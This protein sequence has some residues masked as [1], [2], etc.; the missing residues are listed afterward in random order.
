[1][2]LVYMAN[3]GVCVC[4]CVCVFVCVYVTQEE[5]RIRKACIMMSR[6]GR[7]GSRLGPRALACVCHGPDRI[8]HIMT[9]QVL[10]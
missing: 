8:F 6:T 9:M 1:M 10:A 2:H 4:V 3:D 7:S 5:D